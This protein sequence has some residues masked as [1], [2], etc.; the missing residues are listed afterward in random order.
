M[1]ELG[2]SEILGHDLGHESPGIGSELTILDGLTIEHRVVLDIGFFVFVN[3]NFEFDIELFA[4]VQDIP[5]GARNSRGAGVEVHMRLVIEIADLR[6]THLIDKITVAH[7]HIT[8]AG[9]SCGFKDD[10]AVPRLLHLV[11]RS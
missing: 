1:V 4:V 3:E 7:R 8:T 5:V 6:V 10:N 2:A 11:G 9:F